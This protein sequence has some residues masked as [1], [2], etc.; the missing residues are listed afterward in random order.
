MAVG[1]HNL[2]SSVI[3]SFGSD[4]LPITLS[5]VVEFGPKALPFKYNHT[6]LE[7]AKFFDIGHKVWRESQ[8]QLSPMVN[9]CYK[10]TCLKKEVHKWVNIL[11][12]NET[13]TLVFIE[14]SI[15]ELSDP[16]HLIFHSTV[17]QSRIMELEANKHAFYKSLELSWRLKSREN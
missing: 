9:F 6:W 8:I 5:W 13:Q 3:P 17:H 12:I 11:K 7:H 2:I 1:L 14:S 4:H 15:M 16:N 10:L